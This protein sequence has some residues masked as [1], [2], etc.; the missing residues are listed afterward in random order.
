MPTCDDCRKHVYK[1]E[2]WE[3]STRNG[4][5]VV[6]PPGTPLPCIR[7]DACPKSDDGQPHPERDATLQSEQAIA[8]YRQCKADTGG[9]LPRD[10]I[11][12]RNNSLIQ[13]IEERTSQDKT[14]GELAQLLL[15]VL[16]AKM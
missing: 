14:T 16:K 9:L 8:Y 1:A 13:Q 12:I 11:V 4:L 5:P 6:R 2:T 3:R 7:R 15:A 10:R